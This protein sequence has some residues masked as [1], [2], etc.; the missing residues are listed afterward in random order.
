VRRAVSEVLAAPEGPAS[1][2]D[3]CGPGD[4]IVVDEPEA[5]RLATGELERAAEELYTEFVNTGE[6]P[7]GLRAPYIPWDALTPRLNKISH[8]EIGALDI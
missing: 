4:L 2:L 6:L 5:V 8:L 3:Y 1:L 7:A